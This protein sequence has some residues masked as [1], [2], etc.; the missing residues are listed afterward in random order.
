M[1]LISACVLTA[2]LLCICLR[3]WYT[4]LTKFLAAFM[5]TLLRGFSSPMETNKLGSAH[6]VVHDPK[7]FLILGWMNA[8]KVM[9]CWTSA[10]W[11]VLELWFFGTWRCIFDSSGCL[12]NLSDWRTRF[13]F[14]STIVKMTD[15]FNQRGDGSSHLQWVEVLIYQICFYMQMMHVTFTCAKNRLY[16]HGK[17]IVPFYL[18]F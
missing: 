3:H 17:Y 12:F 7:I 6:V 9:M 10:T 14:T 16:T 13:Y 4:V 11:L 8:F 15:I 2:H 5:W 18:F 1:T